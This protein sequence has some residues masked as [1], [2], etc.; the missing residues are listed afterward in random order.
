MMCV[1]PGQQVVTSKKTSSAKL[2]LLNGL[3]T[4]SYCCRAFRFELSISSVDEFQQAAKIS[5]SPT[6]S[7]RQLAGPALL[8]DVLKPTISINTH[9]RTNSY[10]YPNRFFMGKMEYK[11][12]P[13]STTT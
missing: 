11:K 7:G 8:S 4:Q 5:L 2:L 6:N 9:L 10:A 13:I 1:F 12:C 3:Y